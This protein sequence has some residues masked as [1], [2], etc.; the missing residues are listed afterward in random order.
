MAAASWRF[1]WIEQGGEDVLG[2]RH[3]GEAVADLLVRRRGGDL[4]A[5]EAHGAGMDRDEAGDGLDERRLAGAVRAEEGD[6]L[7][8][9]DGEVDAA[10]DRQVALVAGDERV[11]REGGGHA[12][13]PR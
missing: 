8:G 5:G 4:G 7:A 2:L 6:E 1:S 9:R 11:G 10:H 3:E 13:S 12:A